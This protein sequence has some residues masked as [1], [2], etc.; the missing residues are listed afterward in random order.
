MKKLFF[1]IALCF[2]ACSHVIDST[3]KFEG[4]IFF[5]DEVPNEFSIFADGI[6]CKSEFKEY[7]TDELNHEWA[8]YEFYFE[9]KN[10]TI[11]LELYVNGLLYDY[12]TV[13]E[14]TEISF[15]VFDRP[16]IRQ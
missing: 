2:F 8:V 14:T 4:L 7:Q 12:K 11:N 6:E 9:S 13:D 15:L 3:N 1:I 5:H 16:I 10:E